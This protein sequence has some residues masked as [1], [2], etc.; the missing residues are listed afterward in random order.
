MYIMTMDSGTATD[1]DVDMVVV[2]SDEDV[3]IIGRDDVSNYN[4][5]HILPEAPAVI[6]RIRQWLEPTPYRHEGGEYR[7]HLASHAEGTGQW[8]TATDTYQ[9][10]HTGRDHGLLWIK[11]IPGSG[12]SVFAATLAD[13]LARE[14]RPVLFFFFRQI[15]AA[16]HQPVHMLRD[17]LDQ[18]LEYSPPLQRDL[19]VYV[20]EEHSGLNRKLES[21]GID[22][23]WR[24][25][26][27][28]LAHMSRVYLVADALDEMDKG[29][30]ECLKTLARLG[31]WKPGEVKVLITS[32]PVST[33]EAPLREF[34]ALRIRLEERLVDTDIA[35]YVQ[36]S[37]ASSA[38]AGED[39]VL[40]KQAV[41]GR[42]HGLFLYAKLAMEAFL[43]PDADVQQVLKTLPTDLNA[44]YID[45]LR[46]HA[47]RSGVPIEI[48]RLLLCWVTHATR[49]LRLIEMAE[50]L[51]VTY[52]ASGHRHDLR[53]AKT[54]VRVA[55]GPLL[56]VHPD[57]TVSVVHHSLTEFLLGY[58]RAAGDAVGENPDSFP[59]L[60]PGPTHEQLALSCI[61][62]LQASACLD[63]LPSIENTEDDDSWYWDEREPKQH[64]ALRLEFPFVE[65]AC[66]NWPV[67]AAKSFSAGMA[68]TALLSA[69]DGFLAPGQRLSAWLSIEWR[70]R[71]AKDVTPWHIAARYGLTQYLQHLVSREGVANIDCI[72][73]GGRTPLFHAAEM[74]H[75]A[76]VK[77]LIEAGANPD[78][79]KDIGLKPLHRAAANNHAEVVAVLLAAGVHPLTEKTRE[80]PGL[81]C[82]NA[83]RTTGHTPLMYACQAG[84]VAAVDAFLP[85]LDGDTIQR[86]LNWASREG[87]AN[88]LK[89]L[90]QH[91]GVDVNA[92][93]RG[94]TALFN[95]CGRN[96]VESME[97]LLTAGADATLL[98][99]GADPEFGGIGSYRFTSDSSVSPLEVFCSRRDR[100][101]HSELEASEL[102][103]GLNLLLRAGADLHRR[104]SNL[105]T[106]LHHAAGRPALLRL[107]LRA[108]ADP[109]AESSDGS[110]LLH[111][112]P[113]GE[114]GWDLV[115]LLVEEGKADINKRRQSDGKT[116]LLT[117]LDGSWD[118]TVCLRFITEF[119]PDC[120]IADNQGNTPLHNAVSRSHSRESREL[121]DA[122]LTAGA[123]VDQRNRKGQMAVHVTEDVSIIEQLVNWGADLEAQDNNGATPLMRRLQSPRYRKWQEI[124]RLAGIG[125]R[126]DTRDFR[127]RT[128]VHE[129]VSGMSLSESHIREDL[130]DVQHLLGLGLDPNQVDYAGNTVLHE[131]VRRGYRGYGADMRVPV[132]ESLIRCGVDPDAVNYDGQTVLHVLSA[133]G[134]DQALLDVAIAACKKNGIEAP[135]HQ[136]RRPIHH[137]ASVSEGTVAKLMAAGADISAPTYNGLAPLHLAAS[138]RESNILGMLLAA[139]KTASRYRD[140]ARDIIDA[141]DGEGRTPLYYACLSGRPESVALLLDAGAEV[142]RWSKE[143]IHACSQFEQHDRRETQA[144]VD[145]TNVRDPARFTDLNMANFAHFGTRLDEILGMLVAHGLDHSGEDCFGWGHLQKAIKGLVVSELEYTTRCF[146]KLWAEIAD[147]P[148]AP[149]PHQAWCPPG[150]AFRRRFA[151]IRREA[152]ARAFHDVD[153]VSLAKG[154]R[155]LQER[156]VLELLGRRE[157]DL[158]EAACKTGGCDPCLPSEGGW[159]I[160][161]TLVAL[162]HATLL[163]KIATPDDV[164]RIDDVE[165]RRAQ[166]NTNNERNNHA[167]PGTILPLVLAACKREMPNMDVLRILV[168]KKKACVNAS[169]LEHGWQS[170]TSSYAYV[171]GDSPLHALAKGNWWWQV[172]EALPYLLSQKPDLDARNHNGETPLHKALESPDHQR[173]PFHKQAARLLVVAG[174]DVNAVT[175]SGKTCL[176]AAG[177]DIELVR[178]LIAH[179]AEVTAAAV[180]AAIDNGQVGVLEA[181]LS[182]GGE[183]DRILLR[184]TTKKRSAREISI[185]QQP[186]D[187][188]AL[189]HAATRLPVLARH[190]EETDS[191]KQSGDMVRVLLAHGASPF[192]RFRVWNDASTTA[193]ELSECEQHTVVHQVLLHHGV[194]E[195]FL[196]LADLDLEHRNSSGQTLLLAACGKPSTFCSTVKLAG[197]E[198]D[199]PEPLLLD[200]LLQRGANSSARDNHGRNV[201]HTVFCSVIASSD[202]GCQTIDVFGKPLCSLLTANPSLVKQVDNWGKTPLHY[203][204]ATLQDNFMD[205]SVGNHLISLLLSAGSD[206]GSIDSTSGD[207]AL[208]LLVRALGRN[209]ACL[210]LFRRFL[211][212]GLDVNA[213]NRKGETPLFG[214]LQGMRLEPERVYWPTSVKR[215]G[216]SWT[217]LE[218]DAWRLLEDVGV[219]FSARDNEGRNMLHLAAEKEEWVDAFKRFLAMGLDPMELDVKQR[220]SL[221]IAAA[222]RNEEV[223]GLFGKEDERK[224]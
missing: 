120:T 74:G 81:R 215:Y 209:P 90:L 138:A 180:F 27:T 17:W 21:L 76:A 67:H 10:W 133:S 184:K 198:E 168:E 167:R 214:L 161:H 121:I 19:K 22:D 9:Q 28:A 11:G 173:R 219:D 110:T 141:V 194:I 122:L 50:M 114:E 75:A 33:V 148:K 52:H 182:A 204:L 187:E 131:L 38:I 181:L 193:D 88:V 177:D 124:A 156:L 224:E 25:L 111:T 117:F 203:A 49:P 188:H 145:R 6:D 134:C 7:R 130:E 172:H 149:L 100:R 45:L 186:D 104:D 144:M 218:D 78:L 39:Q 202:A 213:K 205:Q 83:P 68:S 61:W 179:G 46:E 109:N 62:Y 32:R 153:P 207:N 36:H 8:L 72:D 176:A 65:Y 185:H 66:N 212:L 210:G 217:I 220:N 127:G 211:T 31:L 73:S 93:V 139:I 201:L 71:A 189:Y 18:I 162:G 164:K 126:L 108:S 60:I 106:P 105:K 195:P 107:L 119:S 158:I 140:A 16:N 29:N 175:N 208:H 64:T 178:L 103:R 96:D 101:A 128:L 92:K 197:Q 199:Q 165:W 155:Q 174:A 222:C 223:L 40:I 57:E 129:T 163:A 147:D 1:M 51:S 191:R 3:A 12:K 43:E 85:Y 132:F 150:A 56:E 190:V 35:T 47:R 20:D 192:D 86:A 143:L 84:H 59:M 135:D 94:D 183:I 55:C 154:D 157:F 48:Q 70:P 206:P 142:K 99:R 112:S 37:L 137:A 116:P 152:A 87:K 14:G 24:H 13:A 136:G 26:K 2:G 118:I 69:L 146:L 166:E 97:A 54:L 123:R 44:M 89:R 82:G 41:P 196:S 159:T 125:A 151:E 79:D 42:A 113:S 160:L 115:K 169:H 80:N 34:P 170:E 91:P 53:S 63:N 77:L 23:L 98:C 95:A 102:I 15:I 216:G 221:D 171:V 30:D 5:D 200:V 58:T 4:P